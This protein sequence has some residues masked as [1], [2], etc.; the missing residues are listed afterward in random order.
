MN[1]RRTAITIV[2][3][4]SRTRHSWML[5]CIILLIWRCAGMWLLLQVLLRSDGYRIAPWPALLWGSEALARYLLRPDAD[6]R[7]QLGSTICLCSGIVLLM[8]SL[9]H[10]RYEGAP[11]HTPSVVDIVFATFS[12]GSFVCG[13]VL[14]L[15]GNEARRLALAE[16]GA[17]SADP[18]T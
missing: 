9:G 13:V 11:F 1:I 5:T 17:A 16:I 7:G 6:R 10:Y 8:V 14:N 4:A 18:R 15:R 3:V 2:R 12:L